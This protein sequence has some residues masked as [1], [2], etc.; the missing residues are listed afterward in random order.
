M[1]ITGGA[2]ANGRDSARFGAGSRRIV[3]MNLTVRTEWGPAVLFKIKLVSKDDFT[4]A[5][6]IGDSI[7]DGEIIQPHDD[8]MK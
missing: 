8:M 5:V 7:F 4:R 6:L 1:D 2:E 3:F